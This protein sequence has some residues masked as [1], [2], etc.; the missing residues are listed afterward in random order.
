MSNRGDVTFRR[1]NGRIIPINIKGPLAAAH[2]A[3]AASL[4]TRT[5]KS[6]IGLG[7]S[8]ISSKSKPNPYLKFTASGASIASGV[9]S[10]ATFFSR[11]KKF[12]AGQA[13]ALALDF[14]SPTLAA[15]SHAGKGNLKERAK[16][17][18]KDAG[19][20]EVLGYAALGGTLM[21]TKSSRMKTLV[22]AR[23]GYRFVKKGFGVIA[24]AAL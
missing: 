24:K 23:K 5:V 15:A 9:I 6:G 12:W 1:V 11:G 22:Y 3:N 19:V 13:T 4:G 10:G 20:N 14:I 7:A 18:A 2:A 16:G 17:A 8:A 21:L